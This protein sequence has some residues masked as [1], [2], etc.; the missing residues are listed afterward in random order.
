LLSVRR[1]VQ[2]GFVLAEILAPPLALR[3]QHSD[4]PW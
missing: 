3:D 4:T 1:D 2:A